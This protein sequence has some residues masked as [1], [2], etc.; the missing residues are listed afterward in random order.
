MVHSTTDTSS[1]VQ[2]HT[3]LVK[4]WASKNTLLT[5]TAID[6]SI[7]I[8]KKLDERWKSSEYTCGFEFHHYDLT[9]N[10]DFLVFGE[11]DQLTSCPNLD[12]P[13]WWTLYQQNINTLRNHIS[14][15]KANYSIPSENW[16][17]FD[18]VESDLTLV[19]IWQTIVN[20]SFCNLDDWIQLSHALSCSFLSRDSLTNSTQIRNFIRCFS[21]PTQIG[22]M[23]KRDNTIKL[24]VQLTSN[25]EL[26]RLQ[27]YLATIDVDAIPDLHWILSSL[28]DIGP[29]LRPAISIDIDLRD[30]QFIPV[31]SIEIHQKK[32][33]GRQLL[34]ESEHFI[35]DICKI[36]NS[37]TLSLTNTLQQLPSSVQSIRTNPEGQLRKQIRIA[38]LN[39]LKVTL[40]NERKKLKSYVRLVEQNI[41]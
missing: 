41:S 8:T 15:T 38:R 21:I 33:I 29:V 20:H 11:S 27:A 12:L 25:E 26:N 16:L 39:H 14:T 28:V 6:S 32:Q 18:M 5:S 3:S 34:P 22:L 37:Q 30:D 40:A 31:V 7:A 10:P 35:H 1:F 4:W 23:Y 2:G 19:G 24:M 13:S 36:D 17:E 9:R